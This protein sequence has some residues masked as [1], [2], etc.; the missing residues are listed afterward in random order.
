MSKLRV[1]VCM[2]VGFFLYQTAKYLFGFSVDFSDLFDSVYWTGVGILSVH[3]LGEAS[4]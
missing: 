2:T 1:F 3:F 4:A